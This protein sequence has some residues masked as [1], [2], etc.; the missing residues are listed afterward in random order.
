MLPDVQSKHRH[1]DL[2][3][4]G[5]RDPLVHRILS[6]SKDHDPVCH[7]EDRLEPM[8]DKDDRDPLRFEIP[9]D[10]CISSTSLTAKPG[11]GFVQNDDPGLKKEALPM[12]TA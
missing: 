5:L 12:A 11:G 10:S 9:D 1:H 6:A 8:G 3:Q 7:R 2:L 4:G